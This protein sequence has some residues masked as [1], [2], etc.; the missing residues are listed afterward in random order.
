MRLRWR[1]IGVLALTT[2]LV[3]GLTPSTATAATP[4]PGV[5]CAAPGRTVTVSGARLKCVKIKGK[6]VWSKPAKVVIPVP[7]PTESAAPVAPLALIAPRVAPTAPPEVAKSRYEF[8]ALRSDGTPVRWN[9]CAPIT[10]TYW[11]EPSRPTGLDAVQKSLQMIADVSGF[12]FSY[13][14]PGN[15]PE[16]TWS[17]I[18]DPNAPPIPAQL[19]VLFGDTR[20]LPSLTGTTWG[21]TALY[22]SEGRGEI[23]VAYV[24]V[25]PEVNYGKADFGREGMGLVILHELMH[26][27]GLGHVASPAELMYPDLGSMTAT[28]LAAGDKFGLYRVSAAQPCKP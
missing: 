20:N 26:A 11:D 15:T 3:A 8:Q 22:W 28:G 5:K 23:E 2:L 16:P 1:R 14:P 27:M 7:L 21:E 13:V 12:S 9:G 19:Q 10:W 24:V 6:L 18:G 25:R 17:T 4:K